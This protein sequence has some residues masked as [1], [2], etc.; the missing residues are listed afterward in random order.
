MSVGSFR[1]RLA[2]PAAA[3]VDWGRPHLWLDPDPGRELSC[4][5]WFGGGVP[6]VVLLESYVGQSFIIMFRMSC[7]DRCMHC[8]TRVVES[9]SYCGPRSCRGRSRRITNT[10]RELAGKGKSPNNLGGALE[11]AFSAALQNFLQRP[12]V[13]KGVGE[14][15]LG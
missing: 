11:R 10:A 3:R 15:R 14:G 9:C 12:F 1:S 5:I 8:G 2:F 13:C 7:D 4:I 6:D